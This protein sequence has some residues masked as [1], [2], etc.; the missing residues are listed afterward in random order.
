[1]ESVEDRRTRV[2]AIIRKLDRAYPD[3]DCQLNFSTPLELLVA[4]I[5]AA[6]CTDER[7]NMT[8][9]EL[10]EEYDSAEDYA[11]VHLN[12]LYSQIRSC[13]TYRQ[14]G[15]NIKA[16]CQAIVEKHG[17]KVPDNI[18]DLASLPGLGRKSANVILGNAFGVPSI[19][20][21]THVL[22]LSGRLGLARQHNVEKKYADKVERELL[23]VV[24]E[25]DRTRFSHLLAA[26]GRA[27]CTARKPRCPE[28]P[29][30]DLC[31]YEDKTPPEE[32]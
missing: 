20:V 5:L 23:E 2:K 26:H 3:A 17:G 21:D 19:I 31:P 25:A 22:R 7:V 13:G 15:K 24:P 12:H 8:T 9:P 18:D 1:M 14:K 6:Q 11:N 27:C 30:L 10:F 16:A 28:C 29:I 32:L 4:T